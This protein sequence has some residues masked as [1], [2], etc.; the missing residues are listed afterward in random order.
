M[1]AP[2][3]E[4]KIIIT[5]NCEGTHEI[6]DRYVL[7]SDDQFEMEVPIHVYP[8]VNELH[9]ESF[10]DLGFLK[11]GSNH[12]HLIEIQNRGNSTA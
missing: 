9:F 12:Q 10:I 5:F 7:Y 8:T 1:L 2:G 3:L 11:M 4:K 6:V